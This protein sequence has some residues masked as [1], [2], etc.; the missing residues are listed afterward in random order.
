MS[1]V[2]RHRSYESKGKTDVI[3]LYRTGDLEV[4]TS[5]IFTYFFRPCVAEFIGATFYTFIS[6]LT[7]RPDFGIEQSTAAAIANGATFIFLTSALGH[8][9]GAHFNPAITLGVWIAGGIRFA[10][11]FFYVLSQILGGLIGA[12]LCRVFYYTVFY[13]FFQS[14][15]LF[16]RRCNSPIGVKVEFQS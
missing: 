1:L 13:P 15:Q 12:L 16:F 6:C 11:A 9:S 5:P 8:I 3:D 4:T 10:L 2:V 7:T 14:Y